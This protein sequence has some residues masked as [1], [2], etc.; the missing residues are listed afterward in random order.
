MTDQYGNNVSGT[1]VTFGAT[2]GSVGSTPVATNASG[3][4]GTTWTIGTTAGAQAASASVTGLTGSPVAFSATGTADVAKNLALVS[5]DTQT[6]T[7]GTTLA[8]N[9]VVRVTDQYGNNVSGT[10]VTFGATNGSVGSTPV[11]TNASG[12][13]GTTWTIGTTTGAQ[14]AAA[15]ASGLT[16]SPVNFSATGTADVPA[17]LSITSGD[18]QSA[19]MGTALTN[20]LVVNV[21]D[22]YGNVVPGYSPVA[23]AG[24]AAFAA[25]SGSITG[26]PATTNGSGDAQVTVTVPTTPAGYTVTASV[27]AGTVTQAFSVTATNPDTDGDGIADIY[28][29]NTGFYTSATDTGTDPN[30]PDT[31]GD[32]ALDGMEDT[33]GACSAAYPAG[34]ATVTSLGTDPFDPDSDD[35][36]LPDGWENCTGNFVDRTNTGTDPNVSDS[37]FDGASDWDESQPE[38]GGFDLTALQSTSFSAGI[39]DGTLVSWDGDGLGTSTN[40]TIP[41]FAYV[42]GM[43]SPLPNHLFVMLGNGDGTFTQTYMLDLG[44][45]AGASDTGRLAAGDFDGDGLQDL[46][47][48]DTTGSSLYLVP[49]NGTGGLGTPVMITA[50]VSSPTPGVSAMASSDLN[51]DGYTD[52]VLGRLDGY[53][54]LLPGCGISEVYPTGCNDA[55]QNP[56]F[57]DPMDTATPL[58]GTVDELSVVSLNGPFNPSDVIAINHTANTVYLLTYV[59][60]G[61]LNDPEPIIDGGTTG[62]QS[63]GHP[64]ATDINGDDA[65]DLIVSADSGGGAYQPWVFIRG[66]MDGSPAP[67]FVRA[68]PVAPPSANPILD[69]AVWRKWYDYYPGDLTGD[70]RPDILI[71]YQ[72]ADPVL[73]PGKG[74]YDWGNG[75]FGAPVTLTGVGEAYRI[76]VEETSQTGNINSD[77]LPDLLAFTDG[78]ATVAIGKPHLQ[79]GVYPYYSDPNI[80]DTDFDGLTDWDDANPNDPDTDGDGMGDADEYDYTDPY[81][82]DYDGDLLPDG[83]DNAFADAND[84]T[85]PSYAA[86][87]S[88]DSWAL[89]SCDSNTG[90]YRPQTAWIPGEDGNNDH[91]V[92]GMNQYDAITGT[93]TARLVSSSDGG[94]TFGNTWVSGDILDG[95]LDL[96]ASGFS[97]DVFAVASMDPAN[98]SHI[99]L[100]RSYDA[101][102]TWDSIDVRSLPPDSDYHQLTDAKVA[103]SGPMVA[104]AYIHTAYSASNAGFMD[105]WATS[106][107]L[108]DDRGQT[109]YAATELPIGYPYYASYPDYSPDI[110]INAAGEM[111]V[112]FVGGADGNVYVTCSQD[113]GNTWNGDGYEDTAL[114]IY[115]SSYATAPVILPLDNGNWGVF[116][117]ENNG[118]TPGDVMMTEVFEDCYSYTY[119]N[120]VSDYP[121]YITQVSAATAPNRQVFVSWINQDSVSRPGISFD[122]TI[123]LS[124]AQTWDLGW[125]RPEELIVRRGKN[126]DSTVSVA[127]DNAGRPAISYLM[128]DTGNDP[129]DPNDSRIGFIIAGP[130]SD[131]DYYPSFAETGAWTDVSTPGIYTN[132]RDA[133]TDPTVPD[134]DGDGLPDGA[135]II[136]FGEPKN[137]DGDGI[138]APFDN[139]SDDDGIPDSQE[140]PGA[141]TGDYDDFGGDVYIDTGYDSAPT[142]FVMGDFNGDGL[143]DAVVYLSGYS[144]LHLFANQGDFLFNDTGVIGAAYSDPMVR[145]RTADLNGDGVLDIV[146]LFSP[147]DGELELYIHWGCGTPAPSGDCA[148]GA[149]QGTFST[150]V[151]YSVAWTYGAGDDFDFIDWDGVN[152]LDIVVTSVDANAEYIYVNQGDG[153]FGQDVTFEDGQAGAFVK[154]A[155][156]NRDGINDIFLSDGY[157]AQIMYVCGSQNQ[158]PAGCAPGFDAPT[159]S[160]GDIYFPYLDDN[161]NYADVDFADFNG[162]LVADLFIRHLSYTRAVF[163]A[164]QNAVDGMGTG[165]FVFGSGGFGGDFLNLNEGGG[166]FG[167]SPTTVLET[168]SSAPD[169][170][171]LA[172]LNGDGVKDVAIGNDSG[173]DGEIEIYFAQSSRQGYGSGGFVQVNSLYTGPGIA[174]VHAADL[175]LDGAPDLLASLPNYNE[176]ML[177][178]AKR[179]LHELSSPVATDSDNDGIPDYEEYFGDGESPG[180]TNPLSADTDG[181]G[182]SDYD[183]LN[184]YYTDPKDPWSFPEPGGD[185]QNVTP[186]SDAEDSLAT[187]SGDMDAPLD[188]DTWYVQ[189]VRTGQML[190][191]EYDWSDAAGTPVGFRLYDGYGSMVDEQIP[192]Y[193]PPGAPAV[194]KTNWRQEDIYSDAFDMRIEVFVPAVLGGPFGTPPFTRP[195]YTIKID[196]HEYDVIDPSDNYQSPA[197]AGTL[198]FGIEDLPSVVNGYVDVAFPWPTTVFPNADTGPGSFHYTDYDLLRIFG[199]GKAAIYGTNMGIVADGPFVMQG[200]R[201]WSGTPSGGDPLISSHS[202]APIWLNDNDLSTGGYGDV[203]GIVLIGPSVR[204]TKNKIECGGSA[205]CVVLSGSE[206]EFTDNYV[207]VQNLSGWILQMQANGSPD[208]RVANNVFRLPST[209]GSGVRITSDQPFF[210][211]AN[212]SIESMG[213]TNPGSIGLSIEESGPASG[214]KLGP[215]NA[216]DGFEIGLSCD[217]G[218]LEITGNRFTRQSYLAMDLTGNCSNPVVR[219]NVIDERPF[220][221]GQGIKLDVPGATIA[222]NTFYPNNN[223][224]PMID[225]SMGSGGYDGTVIAY[226][227]FAGQSGS[228]VIGVKLVNPELGSA[229]SF[230]EPDYSVLIVNNTFAKLGKALEIGGDD[231]SSGLDV[232][233]NIFYSNV[234]AISSENTVPVLPSTTFFSQNV[235]NNNGI[236]CT[237]IATNYC[238]DRNLLGAF[239]PAALKADPRFADIASD[240]YSIL[241]DFAA[242]TSSVSNYT[243]IPPVINEY[244]PCDAPGTYSGAKLRFTT[245]PLTGQQFDIVSYDGDPTCDIILDS[246]FSS[247]T[248]SIYDESFAIIVSSSALNAADTDPVIQAALATAFPDVSFAQSSTASGSA[249][250]GTGYGSFVADPTGLSSVDGAYQGYGLIFTSG[251][252][253]GSSFPVATYDGATNTFSFD[254]TGFSATQALTSYAIT[255]DGGYGNWATGN[256]TD[257]STVDDIYAGASLTWNSGV[258]ADETGMI[259]AYDG[260]TRQITFQTDFNYLSE[261]GTVGSVP[262]TDQFSSVDLF[263]QDGFYDGNSIEFTSGLL[264]GYCC[265]YIG[266]YDSVSQTITG[267]SPF[268]RFNYVTTVDTN[269]GF[270]YLNSDLP[271]GENTYVGLSIYFDYY[272]TSSTIEASHGGPGSWIYSSSLIGNYRYGSVSIDAAPAPGDTYLI[273]DVAPRPGDSFTIAEFI[274]PAPG[275]TFTLQAPVQ[276]PAIGFYQPGTVA[277]SGSGFAQSQVTGQF[278]RRMVNG[279]YEQWVT[280]S[281]ASNLTD[282]DTGFDRVELEWPAYTLIGIPSA[283]DVKGVR[284][285]GS[286]VTGGCQTQ[287]GSFPHR[288]TVTCDD[289]GGTF[290]LSPVPYTHTMEVDFKVRPEAGYSNTDFKVSVSNV[291]HHVPALVPAIVDVTPSG[292]R[293]SFALFAGHATDPSLFQSPLSGEPSVYVYPN[294][295]LVSVNPSFDYSNHEYDLRGRYFFGDVPGRFFAAAIDYMYSTYYAYLTSPAPFQVNGNGGFVLEPPAAAVVQ[296]KR[297]SGLPASLEF[298]PIGSSHQFPYIYLVDAPA[299]RMYEYDPHYNYATGWEADISGAC[300]GST[301]RS[302]EGSQSATAYPSGWVGSEVMHALCYDGEGDA[303]ISAWPQSVTTVTA[304]DLIGPPGGVNLTV[305]PFNLDA[306]MP[307]AMTLGDYYLLTGSPEYVVIGIEQGRYNYELMRIGQEAFNSAYVSKVQIPASVIGPDDEVKSMAQNTASGTVLVLVYSNNIPYVIEMS[308][309]GRLVGRWNL[310]NLLQGWDSSEMPPVVAIGSAPIEKFDIY[311]NDGEKT[312]VRIWVLVDSGTGA[313]YYGSQDQIALVTLPH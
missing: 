8:S 158:V 137:P 43:Y 139:D 236:T 18:G 304:G 201:F 204:A 122:T 126:Q 253:N 99:P 241:P 105:Y 164:S 183:E 79:G 252:Y 35:D 227:L 272:G 244:G 34:A 254:N 56:A 5:G 78:L 29:T 238:Y 186:N 177:F 151:E 113:H 196:V 103:A 136:A 4:A 276:G 184:T 12:Q 268:V 49:N 310:G 301:M 152:G 280:L 220:P 93:E 65:G 120:V 291:A 256:P 239:I 92:V 221:T 112:A 277:T 232:R 98:S 302:L 312:P 222:G 135:E 70:V 223:N 150:P 309:S 11:V 54:T 168:P 39:R 121:G 185:N 147:D 199:Y 208:I 46:L 89:R 287:A 91:V 16:G 255:T 10:S 170:F 305:A 162:D 157:Y 205:D 13:A 251:Y 308:M 53:V 26:S 279:T 192:G 19:Q 245:G 62:L 51:N 293:N 2:N 175:D 84:W 194:M 174:A 55:S 24:D 281:M 311:A 246:S 211:F 273:H 15:S 66:V 50:I 215:G 218:D 286:D 200:V 64:V 115:G 71:G 117:A 140:V 313:G 267:G 128:Y 297:T 224:Y 7:V 284:I 306:G 264:S 82:P 307:M 216:V 146:S 231:A 173:Y 45:V 149:P 17:A 106:V 44:T 181:D 95:Q 247:V 228:S 169:G 242:R 294:D 57:G 6:G 160:I 249:L 295:Y 210:T 73:L 203:P 176:I 22:Q 74:T 30:N 285:N 275:D 23:F 258:Y 94:V 234:V 60:G 123:K 229:A 240:N 263:A 189:G 142:H 250:L 159:G 206:A 48:A 80:D 195:S 289:I 14:A 97:Q 165:D 61:A 96:A 269:T 32:G 90:F 182:N 52:I 274:L 37:D 143:Q 153:S 87:T 299:S 77:G 226:N 129:A 104:V 191:I 133:G 257:L 198:R 155:D 144:E 27:L 171:E 283:A 180:G 207:Q 145:L 47:V 212:N 156:L 41:D 266:S 138:F 230:P 109:F 214:R 107:G 271:A 100:Y 141:G 21:K 58:P 114:N 86:T 125:W 303:W 292:P 187:Y 298:G 25:A 36:Y 111:A 265:Y 20:P 217:M 42:T 38:L 59:Y 163:A 9:I 260:A 33:S 278:N 166:N 172:D 31:D 161:D 102:Q 178:K 233:S 235:F 148:V 202:N 63:L 131:N 262:S 190:Y 290:P 119:L 179:T 88:S 188:I 1:S 296:N 225:M 118:E 124:R 110:A 209:G 282:L 237:D 28:E 219:K 248:D 127:V 261:Q 132:F 101:G 134:W 270:A 85:W 75:Y 83:E 76:V 130:D 3:Q 288:L 193:L 167:F 69:I 213:V 154:V 197:A 72:G 259:A 243:T 67:N 68:Y 108:S 40:D 116:W 81:D 300:G